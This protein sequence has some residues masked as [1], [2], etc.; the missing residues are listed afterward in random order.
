MKTGMRVAFVCVSSLLLA[1]AGLSFL[2]AAPA[3]AYDKN[4]KADVNVDKTGLAL[5]GYDP[6]AYFT[7]GKATLGSDKF[8]ASHAGATYHFASAANRDAFLQDPT[9]Y[10]PQFGGFCA[11][12][13]SE[14]FKFDGDPL[15]GKVVEGKLYVNFNSKALS[16]WNENIPTHIKQASTNWPKIKD[17]AQSEL[18]P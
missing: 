10:A 11:L 7:D 12:G 14:G 17:K 2:T 16:I 18:Q 9:K 8:T 13:T 15:T 5:R 3:Y 1:E 6:V 4:S